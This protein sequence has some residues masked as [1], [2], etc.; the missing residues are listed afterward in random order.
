M[1]DASDAKTVPIVV[2]SEVAKAEPANPATGSGNPLWFLVYA[3]VALVSPW[4]WGIALAGWPVAAYLLPRRVDDEGKEHWR[5]RAGFWAA[6]ALGY[7][8][9]FVMVMLG[10]Q[11]LPYMARLVAPVL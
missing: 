2:L 7:V 1:P 9:S 6:A 4:F 8:I 10:F 11:L 3:I 5:W